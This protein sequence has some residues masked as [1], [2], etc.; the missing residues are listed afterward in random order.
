MC[1][2]SDSLK[3]CTC[4]D[5]IDYEKDHWVLHRFNKDKDDSFI[6]GEPMMFPTLD[7]ETQEKN[8][9]SL[10]NQLNNNK[11]I[12]DFPIEL[13]NK[14]RLAFCFYFDEQPNY[15][16]FEYKEGKWKNID[17]DFIEWMWKHDEKLH[18][19]IK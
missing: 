13:Q 12:F 15:Y 16:G 6:V 7:Q 8:I 18:G 4:G 14:D 17:P 5:Q 2:V 9:E 3:L 11:N 19:V 10:L 1:K